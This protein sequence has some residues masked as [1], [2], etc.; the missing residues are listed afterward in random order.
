M[1]NEIIKRENNIT[2]FVIN[3]Q[4]GTFIG[5]IPTEIEDLVQSV[6]VN[7]DRHGYLA[8]RTYRNGR[9]RRLSHVVFEYYA[10]RHIKNNHEIH[11]KDNNPRHNIFENL[12]EMHCSE[13]ASLTNMFRKHRKAKS[14]YL[15][16]HRC[17]RTNRWLIRLTINKV[18]KH[19]GSCK[20]EIEAAIKVNK[21]IDELGLNYPKNIIKRGW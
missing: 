12:V 6:S 16:V 2:H 14:K 18:R 7:K 15:G 17:N 19:F 5:T 4:H 20:S 3:S 9:M 11:H 8:L 10:G 21:I 13:H 1:K